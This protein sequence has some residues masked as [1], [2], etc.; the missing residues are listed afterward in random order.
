M[1]EA[2][3][4]RIDSPEDL[5]INVF[6]ALKEP[7]YINVPHVLVEYNKTR[8]DSLTNLRDDRSIMLD[9]RGRLHAYRILRAVSGEHAAH[10][11]KLIQ[12]SAKYIYRRKMAKLSQKNL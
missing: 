6:C 10:V 9:L 1:F 12:R 11:E 4:H 2:K 7:S 3:Q 8:C 5:L